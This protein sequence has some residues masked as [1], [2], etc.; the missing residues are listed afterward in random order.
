M[1]TSEF[2]KIIATKH[3]KKINEHNFAALTV[4]NLMDEL[5]RMRFRN[6]KEHKQ[7]ADNIFEMRETYGLH[8]KNSFLNMVIQYSR[9][10]VIPRKPVDRET[11]I[12]QRFFSTIPDSF[13]SLSNGT[14][15]EPSSID[16]S[17]EAIVID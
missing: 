17:A 16:A 10:I 6:R 12:N 13:V 4:E 9:I 5:N 3:H 11:Y 15:T 7:L 14:P 2:A 1:K 8:V